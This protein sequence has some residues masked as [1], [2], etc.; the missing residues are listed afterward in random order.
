MHERIKHGTAQ[1]NI[2]TAPLVEGFIPNTS[3][4]RA[5]SKE[6]FP[7]LRQGTP[8]PG[9]KA[10]RHD[11][12]DKTPVHVSALAGGSAM[13][14]KEH[15]MLQDLPGGKERSKPTNP[16]EAAAA[17]A[18]AR[19]TDTSKAAADLLLP[20]RS[21]PAPEFKTDRG[22]MT[23]P[24]KRIITKRTRS[25]LHRQQEASHQAGRDHH[26]GDCTYSPQSFGQQSDGRPRGAGAAG[27]R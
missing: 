3:I 13:I 8:Q 15:K 2:R 4:A 17:Q 7:H 19:T 9:G 24:L 1:N 11:Q 6:L 16:D 26:R 5:R 23:P 18:T 27:K 10:R 20:D 12:A 25:R 21:P 22:A 14:L